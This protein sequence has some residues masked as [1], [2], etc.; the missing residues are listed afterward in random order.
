MQNYII[1]KLKVILD[2]FSKFYYFYKN[3]TEK[4]V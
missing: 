3:F 4:Q 2:Y 1:T